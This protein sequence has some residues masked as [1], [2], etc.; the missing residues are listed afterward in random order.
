MSKLLITV[1]VDLTDKGVSEEEGKF[2]IDLFKRVDCEALDI[3]ADFVKD[4]LRFPNN[5]INWKLRR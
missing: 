1:E 3:Q 5:K 2:I 4:A